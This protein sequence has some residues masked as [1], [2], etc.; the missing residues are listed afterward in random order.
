[1]RRSRESSKIIDFCP[2]SEPDHVKT[3]GSSPDECFPFLL[4]EES[5]GSGGSPSFP[6]RPF[7]EPSK[8]FIRERSVDKQEV[9]ATAY[10]KMDRPSPSRYS[11]TTPLNKY[12]SRLDIHKPNANR[13]DP[14]SSVDQPPVHPH[15]RGI[16]N[17][18]HLS[19]L[20]I[21]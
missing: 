21:P 3:E 20:V 5:S 18:Q 15:S 12:I 1:M 16:Q 6:K 8:G 13:D 19:L 17:V 7:V 4:E 14:L 11:S 9:P 10:S 2:L